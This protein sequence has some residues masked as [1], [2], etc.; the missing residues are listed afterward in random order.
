MLGTPGPDAGYA[1]LLFERIRK[2]LVAVSGESPADVKVAITATA[3]RRA[4]HFG[5]GPTSGDLEWAATYWGMFEADSS[6]PS[7]LKAQDRA[8]LFA[9]C[10][11]DFALQRRI[12]LHPSDDSLGD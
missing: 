6:P 4:S 2:R 1:F 12:A 9:G 11:H 7:G 10:A 5:R 3:L 8:S